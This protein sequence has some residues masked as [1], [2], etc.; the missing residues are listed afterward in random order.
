VIL[1]NPIAKFALT[2]EPVAAALQGAVPGAR[3]VSWGLAC[4]AGGK[5]GGDL[6][7]AP[8]SCCSWKRLDRHT[9]LSVLLLFCTQS[10]KRGLSLAA[11]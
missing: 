7:R 1:V 11:R 3:E 4:S 6:R 8:C 10:S 5:E 2:M 9:Q